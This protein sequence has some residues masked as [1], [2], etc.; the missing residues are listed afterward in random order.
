LTE[1]RDPTSPDEELLEAETLTILSQ[2]DDGARVERVRREIERGFRALANVGKAVS[3]FGSARTGPD[4]PFY[5][6]ARALARR[7]GEDGF[8]IVTGGGPGIMEAA[9]R[10]A[11][12]AGAQSIGLGIDLPHEERMNDSVDLALEFHYFFV[13][14]VM[15]VRYAS[16]FVVF[17]GGLGTLDELF[18]AATLR[19][20]EKIRH[21][22][23]VL[24]GSVYWGGLLDWL[25]DPVLAEGKISPEDVE[26]FDV[27]DDPDRV[28]DVVRV[29]EHR[30]P[31]APGPDGVAS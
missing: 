16:A 9:N 4:D 28:L 10:G 29:V 3:I 27:T 14:K 22:P 31:R 12:D 30:R 19:Q 2:L 20:T 26:R 8:A 11:R 7:L 24:F 6:Q 1:P 18:E 5:A 13:R 25:R 23:I 21:F 17:P 15:F